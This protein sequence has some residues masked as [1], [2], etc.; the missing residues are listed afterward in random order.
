[1]TE[2]DYDRIRRAIREAPDFQNAVLHVAMDIA[3]EKEALEL[4][5]ARLEG[6]L[7]ARTNIQENYERLVQMMEE[8]REARKGVAL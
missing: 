5:V 7:K 8:D 4:K 2:Q 3:T 6:E 1:M